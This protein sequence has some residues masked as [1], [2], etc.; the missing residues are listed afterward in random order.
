MY[1]IDTLRA[2]EFPSS[3]DIIHFNNAGIA[4]VPTRVQHAVHAAADALAHNPTTYFAEV[5]TP[6][7]ETIRAELGAFIN[8]AAPEEIAFVTSTSVG[9]NAVAQALPWRPGANVVLCDV[10]F[11]ANVYPWLSLA[12]DGVATRLIPADNG[13]LTVAALAEHVDA[14][15]QAITVSAVQ[16]FTGHQSDLAAIGRFCHERGIWFIVDAIQAIGHSVIDVQAQY[17]DALVTGSQ[18]SLLSVPGTGFAY[19]RGALAEQ[20]Q[21]RIIGGN[22]TVDYLHWL[23]YDLTPRPGALRLSLG[24]PNVTGQ[25]ALGASLSLLNELGRDAIGQHTTALAA[26]ARAALTAAG[27]AVATPATDHGPLVTF[28]TGLSVAATDAAVAAL[29]ARG[30]NVGRHLDRPG[31]A[32][33]RLSFHAY[34]TAAELDR[35]MVEWADVTGGAG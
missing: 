28:R 13:G 21:P 24:T 9:M 6:V 3:R 30:V 5:V 29:Q 26:A 31:N 16:F 19:V 34:N 23:N 32:Y 18:K 10:E 20:M 17:I 7:T 15:T 2:V 8:A 22:A 12:R 4:P 27:Y 35:F 25:M 33:V 11:P 14:Q 1:D